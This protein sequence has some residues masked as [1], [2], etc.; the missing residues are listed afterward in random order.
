MVYSKN[1][2]KEILLSK[3]FYNYLKKSF[4][5]HSSS[6]FNPIPAFIYGIIHIFIAIYF[7]CPLFHKGQ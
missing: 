2:N 6:R 3:V 4:S 5:D 7:P 1:T